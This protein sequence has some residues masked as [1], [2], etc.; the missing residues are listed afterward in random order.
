M[1]GRII[2]VFVS[3]LGVCLF[4]L[5]AGVLGS[6]LMEIVAEK[7]HAQAIAKMRK[8]AILRKKQRNTRVG[9][10]NVGMA[11]APSIAGLDPHTSSD[12]THG[13]DDAPPKFSEIFDIDNLEHMKY[14]ASLFC[15]DTYGHVDSME[16][17]K[18]TPEDGGIVGLHAIIANRLS[19]EYL[20]DFFMRESTKRIRNSS[21]DSMLLDNNFSFSDSLGKHLSTGGGDIELSN[22]N[23]EGQTTNITDKGT[24]IQ[25]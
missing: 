7:R 18:Y 17:N 8:R 25:L 13:M 4:A 20:N 1:A 15:G 9:K 23:G 5:P 19:I 11:S 10:D 12:D 14:A 6:G 24:Y 16:W 2:G 22:R 21:A 3:F